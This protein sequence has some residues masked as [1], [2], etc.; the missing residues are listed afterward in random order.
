MNDLTSPAAGSTGEAA[1]TDLLRGIVSIASEERSLRS[2]LRQTARL[3]VTA[4]GA[5][6][7]FVHVVD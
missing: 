2:M 1:W 7:C 6:A 4:I 5:D 3:V